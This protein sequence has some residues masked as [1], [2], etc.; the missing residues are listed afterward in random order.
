M[1]DQLEIKTTSNF[2]WLSQKSKM[3]YEFSLAVNIRCSQLGK[4]VFVKRLSRNLK[5]IYDD[6]LTLQ[7]PTMAK[8]V[9]NLKTGAE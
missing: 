9:F 1:Q 3:K 4:T 8:C 5:H 6:R 2:D 7:T